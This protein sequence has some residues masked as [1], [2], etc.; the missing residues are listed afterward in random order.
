MRKI[1]IMGAGQSGLHLGLRL[2]KEG[3]EVTI[4][5]ERTAEEIFNGPPT[6]GTY[7]FNDS[8]KCEQETGIDLWKDAALHSTAFNLNFGTPDG[9]FA[10]SIK[11]KTARP[12]VS[13]D[14]RL[15]FYQW[16]K[17]F[18]KRGGKFV[19]SPSTPSDLLD[20]TDHFDLQFL[21]HLPVR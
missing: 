19:V 20:C 8:L 10:F 12:G 2:L 21:K 6:G 3:Y 16:I 5:S 13:I 18:E 4:I 9:N 11:S 15:K 14:Q 17:L 1:A 7:I